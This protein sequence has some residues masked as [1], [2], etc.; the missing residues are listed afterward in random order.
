MFLK[1]LKHEWRATSGLIGLMCA[2]AGVSGLM[3]GGSLR[4]MTWNALTGNQLA[5]IAYGYLFIAAV[6]GLCGCC[7]LS[8]YLLVY[9]FYKSRLTEQGYVMLTLPVGTHHQLLS[10]ITVTVSGVA[11]VGITAVVSLSLGIWFYLNM[12]EPNAAL[13][14]SGIFADVRT[15]VVD[16]LGFSEGLLILQG[17]SFVVEFLADVILLML[18]LTLSTRF[19]KH[20]VLGGTLV[21]IGTNVVL[22]NVCEL[23]EK[24]MEDQA[25]FA[26]VNCGI[27]AL[28]GIA[29]YF[30]MHHI[31]DKKLNLT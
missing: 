2:V 17:I 21:Y 23:L 6:F 27:Y 28:V 26:A 4:Y 18:A 22:D 3:C 11:L 1:L 10:S 16:V 5:V 29:A 19:Y 15:R 12:F 8:M 7:L 25:V 31:L 24:L 20:P 13:D 9:R 14:I 30:L